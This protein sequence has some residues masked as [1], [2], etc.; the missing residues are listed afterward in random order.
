MNIAK[1]FVALLDNMN[2]IITWHVLPPLVAI[3]RKILTSTIQKRQK[4]LKIFYHVYVAENNRLDIG[5][6]IT[7]I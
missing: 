3:F 4:T 2:Q 5:A 1:D 6:K 7:L